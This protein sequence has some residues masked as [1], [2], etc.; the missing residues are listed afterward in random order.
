LHFY[1]DNAVKPKYHE[2]IN[3]Q[4]ENLAQQAKLQNIN[5]FVKDYDPEFVFGQEVK[6]EDK[7]AIIVGI[8]D[9]DEFVKIAISENNEIV[10]F[11][12]PIVLIEK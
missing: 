5:I 7:K 9:T 4:L 12:V 1:R 10:I 6:Y 11:E 3:K 2:F 8:S